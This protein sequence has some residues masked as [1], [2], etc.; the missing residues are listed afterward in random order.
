MRATCP[1]VAVT[2]GGVRGSSPLPGG[3]RSAPSQR[4][5]PSALPLQAVADQRRPVRSQVLLRQDAPREILRL[6][7]RRRKKKPARKKG[8]AQADEVLRITKGRLGPV[9]QCDIDV[10]PLTVFVGRQGTGK[11]LLAQALYLFR[12]LPSLVELDQ[13]TTADEDRSPERIIRRVVD[14]LRSSERS[15]ANFTKP[16]ATLE[17][18]GNL[19]IGSIHGQRRTLGFNAQYSTRAIQPRAAM[20]DLVKKLTT[21]K[22]QPLTAL[23]VPTERLFYALT[24]GPTSLNVI[25]A[26][27]VL[28][29]FAHWMEIAGNIQGEWSKGPDTPEGR[30]VRK[31]LRAE[32]G[33]EARLRGAKWK[34]TFTDEGAARAIDLDMASSGQRANWSLQL[35][36]QVLFTLRA[37]HRLAEPFTL[38]VEEP[39]IHLHPA[40]ERAVIEVL[41]YLVTRG[42]RVVL[43]THS[44]P[45]LYTLN[46]LMVAS[47]LD[48]EHLKKAKVAPELRIDPDLVAA[49][50]LHDG[51]VESVKD[52]DSGLL[53]ERALGEVSD[54]LAAQMNLLYA[55]DHNRGE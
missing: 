41:A 33:G 54:D 8:G 29:V 18:T 39:E 34:W 49:Y 28:Q 55:L 7:A 50:H 47:R 37:R 42:F 16:N 21:V 5:K 1:A 2:R 4:A 46:N 14:G 48:P 20:R 15:F 26:P 25:R 35:L 44:L 10:R 24:L 38:Y 17:W 30:W 9:E 11:S 22:R 53:D 23:F 6:M 45:V 13:A 3:P 36:P 19:A 51:K 40:A 12:G 52:E 43:T 31:H 32:L 27:L